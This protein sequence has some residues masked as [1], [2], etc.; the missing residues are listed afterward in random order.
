MLSNPLARTNWRTVAHE[1]LIQLMP[2]PTRCISTP[3]VADLP[4]ALEYLLFHRSCNVIVLNGGDGTIHHGVAAA[5]EVLSQASRRIGA[6][7]PLPTFLLVNGGGM[8]MLARTFDTRGHP[9]RTL[10]R[11]LALAQQARLGDLPVRQVSLLDVEEPGG[12]VRRGFIFGSELVLN[13]LTMYERFGQGYRGL[14]R[15]LL[16]VARGPVLRTELWQR[17]SYLLDPPAT[18]LGVGALTYPRYACVVATTVPMTLAGGFLGT[19]RA[20]PPQGALNVLVVTA[21]ETPD[22]IRTIPRLMLGRPAPGIDFP[23]GVSRLELQGSYT[24]DG[25]RITR[26]EGGAHA[27]LRVRPSSVVLRGIVA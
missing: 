10:K 23:E 1:R 17:F 25:E 7:V 14:G 6:P 16:E 12:T 19:F 3:S 15:F 22:I 20:A 5:L 27:R 18:P 4:W 9:V 13:A 21:T 26:V 24:L 11:F 2:D 8:N